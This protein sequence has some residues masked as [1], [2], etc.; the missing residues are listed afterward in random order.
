MTQFYVPYE[1]IKPLVNSQGIPS[2]Y[3]WQAF[4]WYKNF[5]L[6]FGEFSSSVGGGEE[7]I[8]MVLPLP[9]LP[10]LPPMGGHQ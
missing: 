3:I 9:Y 8:F 5:F 7:S 4:P 6:D 1:E 2:V 10:Y